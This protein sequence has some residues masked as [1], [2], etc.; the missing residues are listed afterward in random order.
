MKLTKEKINLID[1]QLT[2]NENITDA[3][4]ILYLAASVGAPICKMSKLVKTERTYFLQ[5]VVLEPERV[6]RKYI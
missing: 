5:G 2:N 4:L 6:I 3:E 1:D